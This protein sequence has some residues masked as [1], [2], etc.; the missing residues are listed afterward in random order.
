MT[1]DLQIGDTRE[2]ADFEGVGDELLKERT[3]EF[4]ALLFE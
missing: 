2:E 1:S 4:Q 3:D